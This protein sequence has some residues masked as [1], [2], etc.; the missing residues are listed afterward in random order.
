[1]R[2]YGVVESW[3]KISVPL[4]SVNMFFGCTDSGELL[5]DIK[6]RGLVSYDPVSLNENNLGIQSPPGSVTQL[7]LWR[8]WFYL[9]R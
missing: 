7:I 1:M 9:I 8:I 4:D 5:V 6:D 2:E 3:T